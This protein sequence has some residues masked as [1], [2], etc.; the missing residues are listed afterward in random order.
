[1]IAGTEALGHKWMAAGVAL[2]AVAYFGREILVVQY[3]VGLSWRPSR[4]PMAAART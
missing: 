4:S 1:V 2:H 3:G